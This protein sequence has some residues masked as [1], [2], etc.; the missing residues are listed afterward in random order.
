MSVFIFRSGG[1]GNNSRILLGELTSQT[2][3]F[4]LRPLTKTRL[5]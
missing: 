4:P 2:I 3:T 1:T 5:L